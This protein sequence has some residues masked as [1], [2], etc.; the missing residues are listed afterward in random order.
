MSLRLF[1]LENNFPYLVTVI[2]RESGNPNNVLGIEDLRYTNKQSF[3]SLIDGKWVLDYLFEETNQTETPN[4]EIANKQIFFC[5]ECEDDTQ[6]IKAIV[7]AD[8]VRA[9]TTA[10]FGE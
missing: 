6:K 7:L 1:D 8:Y 10:I 5:E 2:K 9:N 4:W 3:K